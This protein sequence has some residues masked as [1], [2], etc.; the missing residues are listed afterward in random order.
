MKIAYIYFNNLNKNTANT[1]QSLKVAFALANFAQVYFISSFF[2]SIKERLSFLGLNSN[3][4]TEKNFVK[5]LKTPVFFEFWGL[6]TEKIMRLFYSLFVYFYLLFFSFDIIYTRD[7]SFLYFLSFLPSFMRPKQKIIFEAHTIY[8]QSSK[9]VNFS[10]E[11]RALKMADYYISIS[12]GIK[13]DLIDFF[14]IKDKDVKVLPDAV[15]FSKIKKFL[16]KKKDLKKKYCDNCFLVLYAGSFK[17]WKGVDFL[18][19]ATPFLKI[20][21]FKIVLAGLSENEKKYYK[22]FLKDKKYA[23]KIYL[24][25]YLSEDDLF[26]LLSVADLGVIPNAKFKI[27]EKYTSPLKVFEYMAFSLPIV[28]SDLPSLRELL[29]EEKNALFFEPENS[30]D[31]A[32]KINILYK[33]QALREKMKKNNFIKSQN[34]SW[35]KRAKEIIALA[36][37]LQ[38]R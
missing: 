11:K 7:F 28:A 15:D 5:F 37:K 14:G 12:N 17:K 25:K 9:K 1:K 16:K 19:K 26:A 21:N 8:H 33:N 24:E 38:D 4:F 32:E 20:N 6:K 10:M 35:Q 34:Y 2:V 3:Y 23:E 29:V 13:N 22:N 27:G 36:S 18:L 31:L 30:R